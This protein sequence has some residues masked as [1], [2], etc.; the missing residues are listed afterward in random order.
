MI[1]DWFNRGIS[2]LL[3]FFTYFLWNV[4]TLD[5][6]SPMRSWLALHD[7]PRVL[8]YQESFGGVMM[9]SSNGNI[10]RVTGPLCGEFTGNRWIPPIKGQWSGALMFSLICTWINGWVN[11]CEACDLRRHRAHDDVTVMHDRFID[12]TLGPFLLPEIYHD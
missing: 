2:V 4:I 12:Y 1:N 7:F 9:T 5:T 10:F 6:E 11:I 8:I 3:Y